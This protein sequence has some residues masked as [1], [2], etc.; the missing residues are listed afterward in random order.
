MTYYLI[1]VVLSFILTALT[2]VLDYCCGVDVDKKEAFNWSLILSICS[3]LTAGLALS[4]IISYYLSQFNYPWR[5][6]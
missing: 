2:Q 5:N 4:Y 6:K 3:W 1:G